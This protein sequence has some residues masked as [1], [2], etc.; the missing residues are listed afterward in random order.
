[1]Y[2]SGANAITILIDGDIPVLQ[3]LGPVSAFTKQMA[4]Q[5]QE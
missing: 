2:N 4:S 5:L 3:S 1:M